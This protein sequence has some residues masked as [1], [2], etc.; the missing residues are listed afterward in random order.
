MGSQDKENR[1]TNL[2]AII[3]AIITENQLKNW[4]N[5]LA[6]GE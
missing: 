1:E 6:T 4:A 5:K 3:T 2:Q